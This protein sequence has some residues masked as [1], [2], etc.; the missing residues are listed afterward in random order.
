MRN[1]VFISHANPEDNEFAK[2]LAL[3]LAREGYPVWCDLT[4]L[5][6]GEDFWTDIEEAIRERTIKFLYVLS[7]TSN[8]REGTLREVHLAQSIAK[9][10]ELKDFV[11]PLRLDNIKHADVNIRLMNINCID[12]HDRWALGLNEL[13]IKLERSGVEKDSRFSPDE[14]SR[15]W[16][17]HLNTNGQILAEP[18]EHLSNW[19]KIENLP[20]TLFFHEVIGYRDQ[21][22][23]FLKD[24]PQNLPF[25][26]WWHARYL[27]SFADK[28]HFKESCEGR[29]LKLGRSHSLVMKDFLK[30]ITPSNLSLNRRTTNNITFILLRLAWEIFM[31]QFG[32]CEY[33][34]SD[35]TKVF[36]FIRD[37]VPGDKLPSYSTTGRKTTRQ[38]IGHRKV[39]SS[40]R[41]WHL[42][43]Q[44]R[45]ILH[46]D[47]IYAVKSHVLFSDD[48]YSIWEDK[49]RMHKARRSQCKDWWNP[50]WRDTLMA[51]MR[52]IALGADNISLRLSPDIQLQVSR[53]P[54]RFISPVSFADPSTAPMPEYDESED[55][56][57]ETD[58][59]DN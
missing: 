40:E 10:C 21:V 32:L 14:V 33:D 38:M 36:Y 19:F 51:F 22:D 59:E 29:S 13:L 37:I 20:D 26:T 53:E 1:M 50:D 11:I 5:L 9:T 2:W 56:G 17:A 48:G 12:F 6:G 4:Q 39:I 43:F 54:M 47:P 34:L 16:R 28:K 44:A 3:R 25:P 18:E 23:A 27:V 49:M 35:G 45:V 8:H 57:T 41:F 46:P 7:E 52:W 24:L 30:G 31:R 15:W 58:T 42:G 55:G